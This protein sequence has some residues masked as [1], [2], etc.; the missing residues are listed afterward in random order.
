M[1]S[2][3]AVSE[4]RTALLPRLVRQRDA[5]AYLG[6]NRQH[7][8]AEVRP[9]LTEVPLGLRA[10]AYDRLELDAWAD[11]YIASR[12]RPGRNRKGVERCEPGRR[13][14]SSTATASGL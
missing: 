2:Q 11:A 10:I 6:M 12:G 7:F 5:P 3:S 14:S 13:A 9:Q 8:D 1:A 4:C